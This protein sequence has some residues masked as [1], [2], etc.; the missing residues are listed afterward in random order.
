M[1]TFIWGKIKLRMLPENFN[2]YQRG[3]ILVFFDIQKNDLYMSDLESK[4]IYFNI[5]CGYKEMIYPY[6]YK[7]NYLNCDELFFSLNCPKRERNLEPYF[8]AL[9]KRI[10]KLQEVIKEIYERPEVEKITYYHTDTGNENS[11]DEYELVYWKLEE[12]ADKFFQS[13]KDNYGFTPT[14]KIVFEK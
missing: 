7:M 12:F 8:D 3:N 13:I 9:H 14:I 11:I 10:K 6:K 4:E 5:A 1:S 2:S